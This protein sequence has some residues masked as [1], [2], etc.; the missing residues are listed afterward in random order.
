MPGEATGGVAEIEASSWTKRGLYISWSAVFL[1]SVALTFEMQTLVVYANYATAHFTRF[2]LMSTLSVVQGVLYVISAPV[3]AKLADVLGRFEGYIITIAM[4]VIGTVLLATA[5]N[6]TVYFAAQIFYIM[7]QNG[8]EFM[9][10][11]FAADTSTLVNRAFLTM[12]PNLSFLFVPYLAAPLTTFMLDRYNWRWG[13]G[14]W[15]IVLPCCAVPLLVALF[16]NKLETRRVVER[17]SMSTALAQLDLVG[18]SLLASGLLVLF[19][20]VP[21]AKSPESSSSAYALLVF[22]GALMGAFWL[23]EQRYA[24]NPVINFHLILQW[25]LFAVY[26]FILLHFMAYFI[27]YAYFFAWLLVVFDLPNTIAGDINVTATVSSIVSGFIGALAIRYFRRAK[28]V[29]ASGV[30][31][32]FL[33]LC[34]IM[35]FRKMGTSAGKLIFAEFVDGF[36]TGLL[37]MPA[38]V[39]LHSLCAHADVAQASAI[40]YSFCSIG[41]IIG[42]SICGA[43]YRHFYPMFLELNLPD[44]SKEWIEKIVND[45]TLVLEYPMGTPIRQAI[46]NAYNSTMR[47]LLMP[48]ILVYIVMFC[49]L[50]T[51]NNDELPDEEPAP[52]K[53]QCDNID[54]STTLLP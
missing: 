49:I 30:V 20:G 44:M 12:V 23:Y 24:R 28:W 42:N 46:A 43:L 52:K 40:F 29:I 7:G 36:G 39:Y 3:I 26:A 37:T 16:R 53:N 11:L 31:I 32:H 41:Q 18:I 13:I 19:I 48:P 45:Y 38:F 35:H 4:V 50:L 27:Y 21:Q 54:E 51:F 34:L 6:I 22:G 10:A 17:V 15:A 33:G 1:V 9:N 47:M 2:A 8:L 14:T 5:P 25:R